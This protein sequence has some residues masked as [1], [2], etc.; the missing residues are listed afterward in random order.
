MPSSSKAVKPKADVREEL[1]PESKITVVLNRSG[2]W[3]I[4]DFII[5]PEDLEDFQRKYT[6][7]TASGLGNNPE[8]MAQ[9]VLDI[10][11]GGRRRHEPRKP[12]VWDPDFFRFQHTEI[13]FTARGKEHTNVLS[14]VRKIVFDGHV[15]TQ[16][17]WNFMTYAFSKV[18]PEG[19]TPLIYPAAES[20]WSPVPMQECWNDILARKLKYP[21]GYKGESL[22]QLIAGVKINDC[23]YVRAV[24]KPGSSPL[25]LLDCDGTVLRVEWSA[26]RKSR[27]PGRPYQRQ[28]KS[29]PIP[30]AA[31][32]LRLR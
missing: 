17:E 2:G 21:I 25:R 28:D 8:K 18:I 6:S 4:D 32:N 9:R 1:L 27:D 3:I 22:P 16:Q 19:E 30:S 15:P 5:S 29:R 31:L 23:E 12:A 20:G 7:S 24:D 11:A 14:K 13:G 26:I 10:A